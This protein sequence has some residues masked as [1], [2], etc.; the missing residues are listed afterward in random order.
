MFHSQISLQLVINHNISVLL[1]GKMK[2]LEN[3]LIELNPD[4]VTVSSDKGPAIPEQYTRMG[5]FTRSGDFNGHPMWSLH[6]IPRRYSIQ[7]VKYGLFTI[8]TYLTNIIPLL[9]FPTY[10]YYLTCLKL[11]A[12][13]QLKT[14]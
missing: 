14:E 9:S 1:E 13:I 10:I 8:D 12:H 7:Q 2:T 4:N 5:V 11:N 3:S 6:D